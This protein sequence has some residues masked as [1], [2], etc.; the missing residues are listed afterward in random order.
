[1]GTEGLWIIDIANP[2]SPALLGRVDTP[3]TAEDV[4]VINVYAYVADGALGLQS[5]NVQNPSAPVIA[6]STT[7]GSGSVNIQSLAV[8]GEFL[9][10]VARNELVRLSLSSPAEPFRFGNLVGVIGSVSYS[11]NRLWVQSNQGV[12][13]PRIT[14][15][16]VN[17]ATMN[18]IGRFNRQASGFG[19]F[20]AGNGTVTYWSR[21]N[22]IDVYDG[23]G[24]GLPVL[25]KTL[26][27]ERLVTD[28]TASGSH[29]YAS[30]NE[31]VEGS[32]MVLD[33]SN[34]LDPV[35]SGFVPNNYGNALS[36][37]ATAVVSGSG[38]VFAPP[39][40]LA[41]LT[42]IYDFSPSI[43][44]MFRSGD[45]VFVALGHAGLRILDAVSTPPLQELGRYDPPTG[46]IT[47]VIA[48]GNLA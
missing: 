37:S 48:E 9:F 6:G 29:V 5:I 39:G 18:E 31:S 24:S 17:P 21:A 12:V 43:E 46:E 1:M 27:F 40:A 10:T 45:R 33:A 8:A 35:V 32:L 36:A 2:A 3:G 23:S 20:F 22:K 26:E 4:V 19:E 41:V 34:A 42:G 15:V 11:G 44:D 16:V 30:Y 14:V 28:L 47:S 13:D 38:Y 7:L 25:A